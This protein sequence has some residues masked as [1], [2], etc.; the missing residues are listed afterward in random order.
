MIEVLV[1]VVVL[2][3]GLLSVALLQLSLVRSSAAT[4]SQSVALS[5]AK[6][7]LEDLRTFSNIAGSVGDNSI[8]SVTTRSG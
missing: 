4:A 3:V 8:R 5:L 7:K 6:D 1:A 2:S